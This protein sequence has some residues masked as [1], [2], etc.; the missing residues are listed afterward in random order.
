MHP[1]PR[2]VDKDRGFLVKK[3]SFHSVRDL[4]SG[5]QHREPEEDI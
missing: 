3:A 5:Q 4:I 1:E 2:N